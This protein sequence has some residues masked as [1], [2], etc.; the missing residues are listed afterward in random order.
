LENILFIT[1]K[2]A[3][4]ALEKTLAQLNLNFQ[5]DIRVINCTV[6]AFMNTEWIA[7]HLDKGMKYDRIIIP[8][9]SEGD[10]SIIEKKTGVHTQR[11]PD[12]LKE[13]PLFFGEKKELKGYGAYKTKIIAEIVDAYALPPGDILK[14]AGYYRVSGA[15]IIDIG[16]PAKGEFKGI[17]TAVKRLREAGYVVSVDSFNRDTILKADRAGV[18]IVLSV[19]SEN[20]DIAHQV[21][22]KVVVIPDFGEGVDSLN[23]NISKLDN[24]GKDYIIDP[25]L[26]PLCMGFTE[27]INRLIQVRRKYPDKE[28]MIGLG[29]VTELTDA[30]SVGIN[31]VLAAVAAELDIN[32]VLTTEVI[33]WAKGSVKELDIAR[34]LMHYACENHMPPKRIDDRLITIKD[35]PFESF[36]EEELLAMHREIKDKNY[37]IFTDSRQIYIFNSDIFFSG[38]NPQEIFDRLDNCDARHA[39]YLGRELER[40]ALAIRLGKRYVQEKDLRWGHII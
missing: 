11:G 30:D 26:D 31:A 28:I 33:S 39:F 5:Y 37:R 16:C 24:W 23:E 15:D 6:A 29:N 36:N 1:G 27:S 2:L 25:V 22:A 20:I 38:T 19:N 8:G 7:S 18:D 21:K 34:R 40:A 32:Y 13:L 3:A 12:D 10:L 35:P 17:E 4:K 9:L 14:R